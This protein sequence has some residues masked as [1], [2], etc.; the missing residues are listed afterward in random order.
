MLLGIDW[1][2]DILVMHHLRFL[3]FFYGFTFWVTKSGTGEKIDWID[4]VKLVTKMVY[5]DVMFNYGTADKT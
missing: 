5:T 2:V 3:F 1:I 4:C